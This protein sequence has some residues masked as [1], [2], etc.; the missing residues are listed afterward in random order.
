MRATWSYL[1][2]TK[3]NLLSRGA[4]ESECVC[5]IISQNLL[6]CS[7]LLVYLAHPLLSSFLGLFLWEP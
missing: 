5:F 4:Q 1:I 6:G 7:H 3:R 2:Q